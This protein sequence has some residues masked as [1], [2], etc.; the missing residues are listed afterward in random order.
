LRSACPGIALL[1]N[2][3]RVMMTPYQTT[4][5]GF[6][7][8]LGVN[9]LGHFALTGRCWTSSFGLLTPEYVEQTADLSAYAGNSIQLGFAFTSDPATNLENFYVDDVTI[10]D[11]GS[12]SPTT[13]RPR[14]T[15]PLAASL[16]SPG[17]LHRSRSGECGSLVAYDGFFNEQDGIAN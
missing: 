14:R 6:Q 8:Q 12:C 4:E 5:D 9:H 15:G 16:A 2:I 3:A 7:L 17:S 10:L 1:I 13:W 11:G